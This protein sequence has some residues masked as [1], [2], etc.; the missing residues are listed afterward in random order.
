VDRVGDGQRPDNRD[1]NVQL[2]FLQAEMKI[3][4]I[5]GRQAHLGVNRLRRLDGGP[6]EIRMLAGGFFEE[7]F[8]FGPDGP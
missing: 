2:K 3:A 7:S 4:K 5:A 1:P 8:E 6:R